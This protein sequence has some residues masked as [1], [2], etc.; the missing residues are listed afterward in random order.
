MIMHYYSYSKYLKER[1]DE[2]VWRIS[3]NAGFPCPNRDGVLGRDGCIFCNEFGF[4]DFPQKT[5]S[6]K[7]QF[8][9]SIASGK[10]R[11]GVKKFIA[12]FQNGAGTN[13]KAEDLKKAYNVVRC[14]PEIVGLSISTR[15]DCLDD[16][17]LDVISEFL[18]DYDVWLEIG[19]QTVHEKTLK[20]I[21]RRHTFSASR[22][23]IESAARRG[24]KVGAHVILGLPGETIDDALST[25]RKLSLLPVAGVKLHVLHVL[26]ATKLESLYNKGQLKLLTQNEYVNLV[27]D[28]LE[29]LKENC[30]VLRL[31]SDAKME[32]LIGPVWIN[33]KP[34]IIKAIEDEFI[35]RGTKQGYLE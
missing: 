19:V 27:C 2:K 7:E 15:P 9:L 22:G 30:V 31:V 8:K 17:K 12:Y 26:K 29:N 10:K 4:S 23:A 13:A 25:A 21:N 5:A 11:F 28:F 1:F 35:R 6:L 24:I 20:L 33:N 16:E 3:V 14:F 34:T 18:D 32:Y